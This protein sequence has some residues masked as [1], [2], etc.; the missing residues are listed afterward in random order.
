MMLHRLFSTLSD[1]FTFYL[2]VTLAQLAVLDVANA[3]SDD[4]VYYSTH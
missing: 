4:T 1:H 2:L 3:N